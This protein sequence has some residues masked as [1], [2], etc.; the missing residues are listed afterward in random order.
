M[1]AENKVNER[2][3]AVENVD[4]CK[5]ATAEEIGQLF[6]DNTKVIWDHKLVG[7]IYDFYSDDIIVHREGGSDVVSV[8]NVINDTLALQAAFSD[9]KIEF[10][11]IFAVGNPEEG[12]KFGQAVYF[13]GTNDGY[14]KFGP[15]TFKRLTK[16]NCQGMCEC[17][18]KVVD[19]RWKIVEEWTTRSA[20]MFDMIMGGLS[21]EA[22]VKAAEP[23]VVENED[24]E[25]TN[26]EKND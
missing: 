11:N 26:C 8:Q 10:H 2:R 4:N 1:Y 5:L 3:K 14:S 7:K 9:L 20:D 6:I 15:P 19:G 17:H 25:E 18:L 16:E 12:Y 24:Q 22:P 23:E 21:E 13:E